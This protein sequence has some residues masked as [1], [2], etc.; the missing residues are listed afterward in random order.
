MEY[1]IT[2]E[3]FF[4]KEQRN[5]LMRTC[6]ERAMLDKLYGR[7]NWRKRYT[8]IDLALFSGL[9]VSELADL[10]IFDLNLTAKDPYLVVRNGKGGKK[11]DVYL[12]AR[13]VRNLKKYLEFKR[14]IGQSVKGVAYLFPGRNEGKPS[15]FSIMKSITAGFKVAGLPEHYTSHACRHTYAVHLLDKTGNLAYVQQQLGHSNLTTTSL[16]LAVLPNK[17]GILANMI[18]EDEDFDE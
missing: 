4:D 10:K 15:V 6:R 2:R 3:K 12:S 8:L 14:E 1:K 17:N 11:R 16:Y 5:K 13:L 18:D 9:R 7:K